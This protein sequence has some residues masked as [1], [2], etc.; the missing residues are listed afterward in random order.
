[1]KNTQQ[2]I[3]ASL[4]ITFLN[5]IRPDL[6]QLELKALKYPPTD[7]LGNFVTLLG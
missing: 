3:K 4:G 1:M 6:G 2:T 7:L 5:Y